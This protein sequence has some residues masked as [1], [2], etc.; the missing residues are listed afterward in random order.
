MTD[1]QQKRELDLFKEENQK[2]HAVLEKKNLQFRFKG[3]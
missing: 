3:R 2:E 1:E